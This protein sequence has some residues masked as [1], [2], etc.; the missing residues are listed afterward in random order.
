MPGQALDE[1]LGDGAQCVASGSSI[2]RSDHIRS[3]PFALDARLREAMQAIRT[4][5]PRLGRLLHV[6]VDHQLYRV[7]GFSSM[8]HYVRERLGLSLRKAWALLKIEKTVR[9]APAFAEAYARGT[10]SWVRALALLPVVDRQTADDWIVRANTVTVRQLVDDVNWA[11]NARDIHGAATSLGP[12]HLALFGPMVPASSGTSLEPAGCHETSSGLSVQIGAAAPRTGV[13]RIGNVPSASEVCDAEIGFSGPASVVALVREALDAFAREGEPRWMTVERMLRR[14]VADWEA[15]PRHRDPIFTR[16]GW[17]CTVPA[18]SGRRNLHGHHLRF[19]SRG[20]SN[21]QEN[22]VAVCA[23]HHLHGIHR[24]VVRAWGV[25]PHAVHWELGVRTGAA[26]LLSF[27]GDRLVVARPD[28]GAHPGN[29][30]I[31]AGA[32][33]E[34]LAH[35]GLLQGHD[36]LRRDDAAPEEHDV[37]T[38]ALTQQPNDGREKGVVGARKNRETDRVDVLLHGGLGDH[39]RCLVQARVDHLEAGVAERARDDLGASVVPV[40]TGFGDED[41]QLPTGHAP[42]QSQAGSR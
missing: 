26:P 41:A 18:C 42:P 4:A 11:L 21:E 25:A 3:D 40:E 29:D 6:L 34:N 7:L 2:A 19:R 32:G 22:R 13:P 35:P 10:L 24:G 9:R 30:V 14:V 12:P 27:V 1:D 5:E 37:I 38:A 20:G 23:A 33:R 16:D 17:R 8:H 15:A 36:V 39:L 28:V 31:G